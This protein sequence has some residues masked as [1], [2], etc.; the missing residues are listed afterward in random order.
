MLGYRKDSPIFARHVFS[1]FEKRFLF[2]HDLLGKKLLGYADFGCVWVVYDE[3]GQIY[4]VPFA[5][6]RTFFRAIVDALGL[7]VIGVL[8]QIYI[9]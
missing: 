6:N 4:R 8:P 3:G 7:E 5:K 1:Q 9:V 2:P